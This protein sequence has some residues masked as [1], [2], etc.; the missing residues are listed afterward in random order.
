MSLLHGVDID[1]MLEMF[2]LEDIF[3]QCDLDPAEAIEVLVM[4]GHLKLPDY[5][6]RGRHGK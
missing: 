1:E 5:L 3:E 2:S 4:S 6:K